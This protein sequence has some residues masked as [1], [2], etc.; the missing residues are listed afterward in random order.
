MRR[1]TG[2]IGGGILAFL[3]A[4]WMLQGFNVLG[5]SRMSGESFW[6]GAGFVALISGLGILALSLRTA[7]AETR[8]K[9]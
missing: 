7:P 5:G 4:V 2:I 6:A 9:R 1:W 3:G 8:G